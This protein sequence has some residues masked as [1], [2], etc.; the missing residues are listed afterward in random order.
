MQNT[1]KWDR[2]DE[3]SKYNNNIK[4]TITAYGS[5]NENALK[6]M[7]HIFQIRNFLWTNIMNGNRLLKSVYATIGEFIY[8]TIAVHNN[9]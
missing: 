6:H 9:K 1:T 4:W 2:N 5:I 8:L 3:K 7:Y